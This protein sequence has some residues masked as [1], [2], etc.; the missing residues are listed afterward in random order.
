[1]LQNYCKIAVRNLLKYKAY[2]FINIAGLAIGIAVSLLILLFVRDELSYDRYHQNRERIYRLI[3]QVDGASY[4]AIAKV[5]GPWGAAARH[6]IPEIESM[7]RFVFFNTTLVSRGDVRDYESGGLFADSTVFDIFSFPMLKGNP[8]TALTH[9][10]SIIL[11]ADLA[12]KYFGDDDPVGQS[13]R[14][15]SSSDYLVTG[16]MQVPRNSHFTFSFLV[17]MSS[18]T[19][20]R[21]DSWVWNQYYT[22]LLLRR[23]VSP[24]IVESKIP[25]ILRQ[26]LEEGEAAAHTPILQPITDIHLHSN[27]FREMEANSDVAYIYIMSAVAFFIVLIACINFMN[28]TTARATKR[29]KEVGIR[30]ATG[31]HQSLLIKQFL[32]ESI[33]T[34]FLA[35]FL[36]LGLMELLLPTFNSLTGKQLGSSELFTPTYLGVLVALAS[37]VGLVAGSYP[38]FVLA[39]FKPATVLKG[40]LLS[41]FTKGGFSGISPASLR[42]GLVVFQFAITAFLMVATGVVFKQMDFIQNKKLGFNEEQLITIPIRDDAMREKHETV[43]RELMQNPNVLSVA[44]SGNLPGGG[45]YGISYR[46]EGFPEDRVP[47][48]R[49]LVVDHN[50]VETFGMEMASGRSFSKEHSTDAN[51]YLINE[52]AAK[53]LGWED[54][55]GKTIA[56]PTIER[57]AGP[58]IGVLKDFHFRSMH[59]KIGPILLFVPTPDWYNVFT[60]RLRPEN[61]SE[62]IEFLERKWSELDPVYPFTYN[63][64][65]ERFAQLHAAEQRMGTLLGYV[66]VLAIAIACLGLFG[67]A[68]FAAEQRTKEIGVRKVLGASVANVATLLSQDFFKLVLL[69]NLIAWPLAYLAMNRWLEDFAYRTN[70]GWEVFVLAGALAVLIAILT[71]SSQ[72]IRA[73]LANPVES[74]RYE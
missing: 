40:G 72:A 59:E 30:K 37:V 43:K 14:I 1:M 69:A 74:L 54:P 68:A 63:F 61:I 2:S 65:D 73:A 11:T 41:P 9:P 71:V 27:L 53:Q 24:Q 34:S 50:F 36:A 21:H 22:Y 13:L 32:G 66:S 51:A 35:L 56:M 18:Y 44:V 49:I 42:K 47:P 64:F 60:V 67:L 17:S 16:V 25:P 45:D 55:L 26:H 62:T 39:A 57:A 38:A 7:T 33:F 58:V 8:K 19:N 12:E 28:L 48:I 15:D 46:P 3:T 31:A 70:I 29:A 10:N 6:E 20:P 52:E 5:P 4:D 23:E